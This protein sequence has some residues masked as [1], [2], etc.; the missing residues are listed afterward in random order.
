MMTGFLKTSLMARARSPSILILAACVAAAGVRAHARAPAGVPR[1][2][3]LS[4]AC[5][6]SMSTPPT[7]E[8][9]GVRAEIVEA[10]RAQGIT[11]PNKLQ[12]RAL[13]ALRG[14]GDVILGAQTG[15][16]KT[17][18]YL[19]PLLQSLKDEEDC[20]TDPLVVRPSRPRAL[21]LVPTR[22]LGEQV[23][24]VAKSI[25][26]FLKLRSTGISGGSPL[27][28]QAKLLD[29]P[30]DLLVATPGRLLAHA[31][32]GNV[33]F[34]ATSALVVDEVDTIFEAGFADD[35]RKLLRLIA[36]H[37]AGR[38]VRHVV[39]GATHPAAAKRLYA[40][41]FPSARELMVDVHTM[42]TQLS[43]R[44]VPV[45]SQSMDKCEKLIEVLGPPREDGGL[46][47]V[48]T[49]IF[50]NSK[51]SARFV[52]HYLTERRQ[53]RGAAE[54][55]SPPRAGRQPRARPARALTRALASRALPLCAPA[56]LLCAGTRR[57]TTTVASCLRR[58]R[59]TSR[60][61]SRAAPRSSS[62]PTSPRAAWTG[63][64]SLTWSS[65][66]LR[67]QRSTTCT[68]R[69]ARRARASAGASPR[70]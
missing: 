12:A 43:Q 36:A 30:L 9:L 60:S 54:A 28:K 34:S 33:G 4:S 16:G 50:C 27:G 70:S 37:R 64:T 18:T 6:A 48:R 8:E 67:A 44:F 46:G 21:V 41:A 35:L 22:E 55:R 38:P 15:S 23:K 62:A 42:P 45:S 14:G 32:A 20:A 59:P 31:E 53:A 39:V 13:P 5:R 49:L 29:A 25:C 52:D 66:T 17:L 24:G 40:E 61:S 10:L 3:A 63:W 26:H 11:S 1:P 56:L 47:G 7:F 57:A 65:L 69:G 68:E 51:D 2:R 58:A 19:V